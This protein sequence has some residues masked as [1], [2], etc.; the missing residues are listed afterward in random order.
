M[1]FAVPVSEA[2]AARF[3]RGLDERSKVRDALDRVAGIA[4]LSRGP[5]LLR[6]PAQPQRL[7]E[8][9]RRVRLDQVTLER[10]QHHVRD[11]AQVVEARLVGELAADDFGLPPCGQM[12]A[13]DLVDA[14]RSDVRRIG[15]VARKI[16][17]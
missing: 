7:A 5:A 2:G 10:E 16:D 13:P 14:Q 3:L 8:G 11:G 9:A 17:L 4:A 15:P 12:R 1:H 6:A